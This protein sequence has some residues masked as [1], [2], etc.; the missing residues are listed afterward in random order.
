MKAI[1][2]LTDEDGYTEAKSEFVSEVTVR[3]RNEEFDF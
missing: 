3:A 2:E 1:D